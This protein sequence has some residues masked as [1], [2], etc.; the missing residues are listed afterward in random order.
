MMRH[1]LAML[2]T[3]Y[4]RWISPMKGFRCAYRAVTGGPSCSNVIR[5]DLLRE[6]VWRALP[7]ARTQFRRCRQ[8]YASLQMSDVR[9]PAS[10]N[11]APRHVDPAPRHAPATVRKKSP[12]DCSDDVCCAAAELPCDVGIPETACDRIVESGDICCCDMP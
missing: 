3:L 2:I 4:Q 12:K 11:D 7:L 6:G 5:A 9:P 1:L 8:A 10:L